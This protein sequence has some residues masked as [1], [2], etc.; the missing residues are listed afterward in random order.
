MTT[1]GRNSNGGSSSAGGGLDL[2]A[3][4]PETG[5]V[6]R[7]LGLVAAVAFA[8]VATVAHGA[9]GAAVAPAVP[10][11]A[12][13]QYE[14]SI[15]PSPA[16]VTN[17]VVA[18]F[19]GDGL[20]DVLVALGHW[21]TTEEYPVVL[22][23]N[24]GAGHLVDRSSSVFQ[25]PVPMT[26]FPYKWVVAD[27]NGDKIPDVFIADTGEDVAN[28]I[29]AHSPLILSAP[30][31]HLVDA[32]ANLPDQRAYTYYTDAADVNGDGTIDLYLGN[33]QTMPPEILLNDGRGHFHIAPGALPAA[34]DP[35]ANVTSGRFADVNGDGAPDL[36][37]AGAD[38]SAG[39]PTFHF[40]PN[41]FVLL[42]DGHG[43]FSILPNSMPPKPFPM[44]GEAA[45]MQVVNLNGDAIPDLLITWMKGG[46]PGG[47][48][49]HW[50]QVLIG[51]GDGTFRDETSTRL[52]QLDNDGDLI[53]GLKLVDLNRDGLLDIA[54]QLLPINPPPFDPPPPFYLNDGHG[55]F[56]PLPAGD[57]ADV[58]EEYAF[59]DLD[60]DGGHDIVYTTGDYRFLVRREIGAPV[61]TLYAT[62]GSAGPTL[63]ASDDSSLHLTPGAYNVVVNDATSRDGFHLIG[64]G[65]NRRTSA[66][67]TGRQVWRVRLKPHA[68]YRYVTLRRPHATTQLRTR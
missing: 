57:N 47:F 53:P 29:G 25:G 33:T 22:L 41:T 43:H 9:G 40:P 15:P 20:D 17:M 28:P 39:T 51:N 2:P 14:L 42:N 63:R 19:T 1:D 8:L 64:P 68:T 24:D 4:P 37:V 46:R 21:P 66:G 38:Y 56:T 36:V 32:T 48:Y 58:G 54:T 52:P 65:V 16:Y 55:G 49:G 6:K 26:V 60:G 7:D 3:D 45:D 35:P 31:G 12:P 62:V 27:F 11:F 61:S 59:V 34:I 23:V 44:T 13:P 50:I 10:L 18:D 30:G 5:A 67:F